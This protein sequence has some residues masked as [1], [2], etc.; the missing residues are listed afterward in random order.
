MLTLGVL[1]LLFFE[2]LY[3][4]MASLFNLSS[5]PCLL[6]ARSMGFLGTRSKEFSMLTNIWWILRFLSPCF[7][8]SLLSTNLASV[9]DFPGM[10]KKTVYQQCLL[11]SLT[12]NQEPSLKCSYNVRAISSLYIYQFEV[13]HLFPSKRRPLGSLN[14]LLDTHQF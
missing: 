10:K 2:F 11:A 5:V 14:I 13:N 9:H 6:R 1:L 4:H 7:S 3:N 12:Y 8:W